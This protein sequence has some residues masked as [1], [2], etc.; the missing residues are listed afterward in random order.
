[1]AS[2]LDVDV[3][4]LNAKVAEKLKGMGVKAPAF[5]GLVK[6]GAHNDRPPEQEDFFFLRCA[7]MM[8]QAYSKNIV[9]VQRLRSHYGGNKNRGVRPNRHVRAGGSTIRKAFQALEKAG[10]MEKVEK[11]VKKGRKLTAAGRKLLDSSA[12]D[13][14]KG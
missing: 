4:K 11:G 6:A 3:N 12:K 8:R 2:A 1:M 13:V 5:V 10:F 7:S 9:G 14:R